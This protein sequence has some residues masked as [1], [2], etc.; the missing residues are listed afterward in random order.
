MHVIKQGTRG[1]RHG[2]DDWPYHHWTVTAATTNVQKRGFTTIANRWKDDPS[3]R[4]TQRQHGWILECCISLKLPHQ[5]SDSDRGR[6]TSSYVRNFDGNVKIGD[7]LWIAVVIFI[8]DNL[9]GT[10][11][12]ARTTP[13]ARL[14]RM[15]G[16]GRMS[17]D[18]LSQVTLQISL[19]VRRLFF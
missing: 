1:E 8:L 12:M 7:N 17:T 16:M 15:E 3:Y 19:P 2:L 5:V 18:F 14:A 10:P 4:E 11:T 13:M 6:S 9:V